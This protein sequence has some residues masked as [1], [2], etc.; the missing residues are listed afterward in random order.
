MSQVESGIR[1]TAYLGLLSIAHG[2]IHWYNQAFFVILPFI[3]IDYGLSNSQAGLLVAF[4]SLLVAAANLPAAIFTDTLGLRR[5]ILST[6][7]VWPAVGYFIVGTTGGLPLLVLGALAIGAGNAQWH[8]PAMSSLADRFPGRKG[9]ALSVHELGANVGDFL[10]PLGVGLAI[11]LLRG[12][13]ASIGL[14]VLPGLIFALAIWILVQEG[15]RRPP[16]S[17]WAGYW[18]GVKELVTHRVVVVLGIISALR[19]MGQIAL[20]AFLPL[21]LVRGLGMPA[22]S[23]G[24]YMAALTAASLLTGPAM[25]TLSDRFGRK[26]LMGFGLF[27]AGALIV[28]L[29]PLKAGLMFVVALFAI[30]L[31]LFSMRP[32]IFAYLADVV[33]SHLGATSV[34][35]LFTAN[36][37]FSALAPIVAGVVGDRF[38][39][40]MAFIVAGAMLLLSGILAMILPRR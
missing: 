20:L 29:T 39:L 7:L 1:A 2:W 11:D 37:A 16:S 32:V 8:P 22:A 9:M 34:G 23:A 15:S 6:S 5:V 10:A 12:W 4:Q 31:F 19:T 27:A 36:M 30:G 38:G 33:P 14:N 25:G 13:R 24:V 17:D 28:S 21:Y 40:D 3:A 26:P 18:R 35:I